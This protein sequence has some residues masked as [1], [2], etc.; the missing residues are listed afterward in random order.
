MIYTV[1][2][3]TGMIY[4]SMNIDVI[5]LIKVVFQYSVKFGE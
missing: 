5:K 1:M 3:Y 4:M 2:I